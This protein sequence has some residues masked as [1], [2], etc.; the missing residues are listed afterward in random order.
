MSFVYAIEMETPTYA[1]LN[2]TYFF[3]NGLWW[4]K[5]VL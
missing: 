5:D 2:D 4:I 3:Y 1:D